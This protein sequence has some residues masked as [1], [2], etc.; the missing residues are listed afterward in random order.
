MADSRAKGYRVERK[1]KILFEGR[2]WLVVRAGRS[3]GEADL[4]CLKGGKC[5]LLQ[6]KSTKKERFYYYGVTERTVAGFPF[7]LV[8]DFGYGDMRVLP[9]QPIVTASD[10]DD[11][12]EFLERIN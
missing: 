3:L 6:V 8:V 10:G 9:P 7:F 11:M 12:N 2:G 1:I 5:I 4:L